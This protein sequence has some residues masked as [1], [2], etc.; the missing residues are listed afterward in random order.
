MLKKMLI[1]FAISIAVIC[2]LI[3]LTNRPINAQ[4]Q[5]EN[6]EVLKRLDQ[7]LADQKAILDGI[8]ALKQ[9]IYII[10]IRVTQQQ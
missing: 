4:A 3:M 2:A 9:E 10:K 1:G 7:V 5:T 6:L 8:E